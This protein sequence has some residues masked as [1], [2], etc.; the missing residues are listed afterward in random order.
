M[1][2]WT[3]KPAE[4]AMKAIGSEIS[5]AFPFSVTVSKDAS[6]VVTWSVTVQATLLEDLQSQLETLLA[7]LEAKYKE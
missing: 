5:T 1:V 4:T 3:G 7:M 2:E 6:K